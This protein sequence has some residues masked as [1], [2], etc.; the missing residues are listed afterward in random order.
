LT[1]KAT[2]PAGDRPDSQG[3]SRAIRGHPRKRGMRAVVWAMADQCGNQFRL[4]R[5][6][7]NTPP[8]APDTR[9]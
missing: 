8:F 7:G 5:Q 6:D 4:S 2:D 9:K 1:R 3:A